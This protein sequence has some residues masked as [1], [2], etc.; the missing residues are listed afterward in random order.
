MA[1]WSKGLVLGINQ[2]GGLG[3]NPTAAFFQT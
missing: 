2:V 3:S 1:E